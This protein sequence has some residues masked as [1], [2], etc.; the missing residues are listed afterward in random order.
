MD[1]RNL[2]AEELNERRREAVRLRMA[3][4]TVAAVSAAVRL[5]A[6]TVIAAHKAYL[7]GGWDAV[8]LRRRGR[9]AGRGPKLDASVE[10]QQR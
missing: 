1:A 7:A 10:R 4:M 5:S 9:S 2:P 3:G 8:L 6:P